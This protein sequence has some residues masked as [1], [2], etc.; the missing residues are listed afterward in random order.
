[1]IMLCFFNDPGFRQFLYSLNTEL[2]FATE[3]TWLIIAIVISMIA[4]AVGGMMLAGKEIGYSFAATIGSLFAPAGVIPAIIL[5][6]L[7]LSFLSKY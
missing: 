4:G 6:L 1:M 5:G 2:N 7:M 3:I